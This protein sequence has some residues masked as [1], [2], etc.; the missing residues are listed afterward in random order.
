MTPT[1]EKRIE[2]SARAFVRALARR[3][4]AEV[5]PHVGWPGD[6]VECTLIARRVGSSWTLRWHLG[7][8][9][10]PDAVAHSYVTREDLLNDPEKTA[11][12][13]EVC[14]KRALT[15]QL[16]ASPD[17]STTPSDA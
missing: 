11:H 1:L 9:C 7:D 16:A 13:L 2:T 17:A 5:W 15:R 10:E 3:P 12:E 8:R 4:L 6:F 14:A